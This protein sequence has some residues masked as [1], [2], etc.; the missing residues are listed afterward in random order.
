MHHAIECILALWYPLVLLV[1][2]RGLGPP[3]RLSNVPFGPWAPPLPSYLLENHV[4]SASLPA[5]YVHD[6][7]HCEAIEARSY[8]TLEP[9]PL[10]CP[11]RGT[12]GPCHLSEASTHLN[13]SPR[14]LTFGPVGKLRKQWLD[15]RNNVGASERKPKTHIDRRHYQCIVPQ[16]RLS[17]QSDCS[18]HR[19]AAT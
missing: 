5:L 11:L 13:L 7:N 6:I 3:L 1:P 12:F 4:A 10:R 8:R 9:W 17:S 2:L 19:S 15:I 14:L 16:C 18:D